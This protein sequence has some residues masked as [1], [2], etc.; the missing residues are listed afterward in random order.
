M[1][2]WCPPPAVVARP[3]APP[4]TPVDE[5]PPY[6]A[7]A[8]KTRIK[9]FREFVEVDRRERLRPA[10]PR[11]SPGAGAPPLRRSARR[12]P[13]TR[14]RLPRQAAPEETERT[15]GRRRPAGWRAFPPGSPGI[16]A[17]SDRSR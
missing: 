8:W 14:R 16:G 11:A 13:A 6:G 7:D 9:I 10:P 4:R 3:P 17:A 5:V 1:P 2:P 15:D 12:F